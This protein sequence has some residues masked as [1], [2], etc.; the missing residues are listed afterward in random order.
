[1]NFC[2]RAGSETVVRTA[3]IYYQSWAIAIPQLEES[4]SAIAIPQLFKAML[5]RNR[6]SAIPQSQFFLKSA[7]WELHFRN[8]RHIFDRGEVR[9]YIFFY[10]QVFFAFESF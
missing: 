10:H 9:N 3:L 1:M 2:G 5:I 6:N 4:P 8:L 7:T